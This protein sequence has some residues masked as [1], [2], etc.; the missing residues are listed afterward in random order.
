MKRLRWLPPVLL[1][2]VSAAPAFSQGPTAEQAIRARRETS[3]LAIAKH[4]TAGIGAILASDVVIVTSA[5]VKQSGRADAVMRFAEQFKVRT[6]VVY[7]RTPDAVA[8]FDPWQMASERGHWTG[9][10]S[11]PDGKVAI[12]GSYFAKW[13]LIKGAWFV[14]SETYVPERCSGSTFC[15]KVP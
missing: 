6:D 2:V 5:S 3:N 12:G 13:R 9:S 1:S 15:T 14:E 11:E 8:V 10:W 4:D 7:R